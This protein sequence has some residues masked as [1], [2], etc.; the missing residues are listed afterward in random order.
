MKTMER[1][2]EECVR[3]SEMPRPEVLWVKARYDRFRD[4]HRIFSKEEADQIIFERMYGRTAKKP[5]EILKIR[6]W[7]TGKHLPVNREQCQSFGKA[8][9]LNQEDMLFLLQG[10]YDRSDR[11]FEA[12]DSKDL[13]YRA[14]KE[15]I[16]SLV[17]EYLGKVHPNQFQQ[18]HITPNS[19]RK[20][21][22]HIYFMDAERYVC[23]QGTRQDL[24][25]RYDSANY[26][27]EFRRS[28]KLLGE[29]PRK[30]ILRHLILMGIPYLNREILDDRLRKLGYLPLSEEHTAVR[31]ER[32]D[33]LLIRL[34]EQYQIT[35]AGKEPEECM[36]WF[37]QSL[38]LLDG[39]FAERG[40]HGLCFMYFKAMQ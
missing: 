16:D 9:E 6:Y 5:S 35:C 17:E 1:F 32:L 37:C 29:I 33:W 34:F 2:A 21:L 30:T 40:K 26:G 25:Q 8:L 19:L 7:R 28:L 4:K 12:G 15:L 38:R 31:G 36:D 22:R 11:V 27:S 39:Y 24:K 20:N 14:R 23:L 13:V 10:Y 18:L 3:L